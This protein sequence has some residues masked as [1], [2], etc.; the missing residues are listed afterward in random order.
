MTDFEVMEQIQNK[1][2]VT[3]DLESLIILRDELRVIMD[4]VYNRTSVS[5]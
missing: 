4:R 5:I 1:I 3:K 2:R